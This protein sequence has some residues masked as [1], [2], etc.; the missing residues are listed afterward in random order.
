MM[1][2]VIKS[3]KSSLPPRKEDVRRSTGK[4]EKFP[5]SNLN[6]LLRGAWETRAGKA[7]GGS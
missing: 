1:V 7:A 3:F 5:W 6:W 2:V 4:P